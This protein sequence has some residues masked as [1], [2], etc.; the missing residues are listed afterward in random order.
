MVRELKSDKHFEDIAV[1]VIGDVFI[2]S[3]I[4]H[5]DVRLHTTAL[6][7]FI[8]QYRTKYAYSF[9]YSSM[10]DLTGK[11]NSSLG[12]ISIECADL[13]ENIFQ[14]LYS[15][16]IFCIQKKMFSGDIQV[17]VKRSFV[18]EVKNIIKDLPVILRGN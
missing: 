9:P 3:L 18:Y 5:R 7:F 12:N 11:V 17:N 8:P 14:R 10:P 16:N 2:T 15:H 13:A 4:S 1:D 6:N